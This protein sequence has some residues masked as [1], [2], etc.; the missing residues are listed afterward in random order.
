MWRIS[1]IFSLK[2]IIVLK[3][4]WASARDVSWQ[5][6]KW[7]TA[8]SQL[9]LLPFQPSLLMTLFATI[10]IL[11]LPNTLNFMLL[12][13]MSTGEENSPLP[14]SDSTDNKL[15]PGLTTTRQWLKVLTSILPRTA[16]STLETSTDYG[17]GEQTMIMMKMNL[18]WIRS[19]IDWNWIIQLRLKWYGNGLNIWL[20]NLFSRSSRMIS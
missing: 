11:V 10:I 18:E 5:L 14:P 2:T 8:G 15:R 6:P 13:K 9:S 3:W 12:K 16:S 20:I 4:T 17:N 7:L 19:E 1:S